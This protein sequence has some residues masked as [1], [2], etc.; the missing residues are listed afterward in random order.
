M[1]S[2]KRWLLPDGVEEI[3]PLEASKLEYLRRQLLDLYE[4]WGYQLVIT[5]LIEYLDSLLVGSSHDLDLHTFK[6]TDQLSGRMLGIRA[7]ITPQAARIDAHCMNR[8][9]PVRLCYADNVLHTKPRGLLASRVPIRVGA[10]LYGHSGVECDI[11]LICLMYA[12]LNAAAIDNVYIVLGHV[13]IFRALVKEAAIG[14]DTEA[15]LFDAV[16]RK[17]YDEIDA[18]LN[19]AVEDASLNAMLK[20]LTR[21]S[22]DESVLQEA[23]SVFENASN[24]V[25]KVLLE[26][27]L[28]VEGVKQRHPEMNMCFDLCELRGYE[29][30]TG[31]VFAAYTPNYGRAVAKGGRYD[32]IGEVFGRSR[33][34][35]GFDSD[36]KT[37]ARL[38]SK[39]FT[40]KKT[41]LAPS[42]NEV[43]LLD[44]IAKL[45]ADGEIVIINLLVSELATKELQDLN[46]DRQ[47]QFVDGKWI[48]ENLT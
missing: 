39:T 37:I 9:G 24:A 15:K 1:T 10:E 8:D 33:P 26:L 28:I 22:G 4:S 19:A 38:S 27:V 48:V 18:V 2:A 31:I 20:Q 3:L 17:A 44:A 45:R 30:H 29:Y 36:L 43:E 46:C 35:S 6:I 42:G 34:A 16:Q 5:P 41:I 21:F 32:H 40:Q 14:P 7:D 25:T 12:T 23:L 13:G 47:L 11:E